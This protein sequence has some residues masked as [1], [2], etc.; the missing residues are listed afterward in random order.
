[1]ADLSFNQG[2]TN[3]LNPVNLSGEALRRLILLI[4]SKKRFV[5][6]CFP[7]AKQQAG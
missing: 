6:C 5:V 4:L 1:M 7:L 3:I 2:K